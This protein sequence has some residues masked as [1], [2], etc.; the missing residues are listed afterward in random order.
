MPL[1]PSTPKPNREC[2]TAWRL[3]HVVPVVVAALGWFSPVTA[4]EPQAV[5]SQ[6]IEIHYRTGDTGANAEIELW[7]TRDRG[8]TWKKYG[9]DP[10]GQSPFLFDAPAEGLYGITL[11][12]RD[13]NR[14]SVPTPKPF[15]QPQRWIFID[16][17]PPLAQWLGVEPGDEFALRRTVQLRWTAH[18]DNMENRPI[19]LAWQSSIDQK[20]ETI[21]NDLPNSGRYDWV[22]P[23]GVSGQVTLKLS[24]RDRGGHV[25]ER[26]FGPVPVAAW[27]A[28]VSTNPAPLAENTERNRAP[29]SAPAA[30][31]QP[32]PGIDLATRRKAEER[33][34]QG[35]WHLLRGQY[36][37]AAERFKEA[38]DLDPGMLEAKNDLAGIY[39]LQKDYSKATE[40]Y[41]DVLK[42]DSGHVAAMRGAALAYVAR[43]QYVESRDMLSR[44]LAANDK[45]A[46]AALDLGDVLFMM[47]DR[48]GARQRWDRAMKIDEAAA[49]VI[50]KAHRRL[51]LYPS[52][53]PGEHATVAAGIR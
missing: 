50:E 24:V 14:A 40:L 31:T 4:T 39:Y 53:A 18:D 29:T 8:A 43:K 7:Y 47:G 1:F 52:T 21:A 10:N 15:D 35:S 5:R 26:L 28:S 2:V 23:T 25:V 32:A 46:E 41:L 36:A 11:I 19:S 49:D 27:Q 44:L 51:E 6:T 20:W 13:G 34:K 17:T 3:A 48:Q 12:V 38:L 30:S 37:L 16:Y 33:Y 9:I 42:R 45:D 22:V